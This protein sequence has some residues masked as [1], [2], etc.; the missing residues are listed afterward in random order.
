[1]T[2]LYDQG[3]W[4][5]LVADVEDRIWEFPFWLDL[6]RM[7]H[8]AMTNLGEEYEPA[9][10]AVASELTTLLARLPDV[11]HL[12]FA[13]GTPFADDATQEWVNKEL[14]TP[15]EGAEASAAPAIEPPEDVA[16]LVEQARD[17]RKKKKLN[18]AVALLQKAMGGAPCQRDRFMLQ[19]ELAKLCGDSGHV[20]PALAHLESLD[21]QM[22][23]FTL[24]SWEP[25]LSAEVLHAYWSALSEVQKSA[26]A[27]IAGDRVDEV[28]GRLCRLDTVAGLKLARK[29]G[30][31][32]TRAK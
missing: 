28:Y 18:D 17:L 23:E 9:R 26:P 22:S 27:G 6:H 12:Q 2:S 19:F 16:V 15:Q 3:S 30:G 14:F 4:Q 13:D 7:T 32:T 1:L 31:K 20:K 21:R 10:G 25:E 5:Q 29:R 8:V 24:E 11:V